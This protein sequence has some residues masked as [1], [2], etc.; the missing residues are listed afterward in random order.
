MK[1]KS[2][3][4]AKA[5]EFSK[6]AREE[7]CARDLGQCIFCRMK[8]HQ[9]ESTWLGRQML[10]VMHYIPRSKG[11]LGIPENGALGCAFHHEMMDNGYHGRR[12]EM[13][14]IFRNYL[15]EKHPKWNEENLTYDKWR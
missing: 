2:S 10:S 14:E 9:E 4:A 6:K 7:I 12:Q 11:G 8:Y 13:L 1:N 15:K 3:R 5:H